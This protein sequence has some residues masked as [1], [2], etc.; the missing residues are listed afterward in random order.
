MSCPL[1]ADVALNGA[2]AVTSIT[3]AQ[4]EAIAA[5]TARC[6]QLRSE[7]EQLTQRQTA[8]LQTK[9]SALA[10]AL[11][12]AQATGVEARKLAA[13]PSDHLLLDASA[14]FEARFAEVQRTSNARIQDSRSVD[15]AAASAVPTH[16]P[17]AE[18][19]AVVS[20]WGGVGGPGRFCV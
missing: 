9:H 5:V 20:S 3:R 10:Q 6:A 11:E 4:D 8:V 2:A 16:V 15:W 14:A 12:Q 7:A 1:H 17:A 19:K 18:L 13:E